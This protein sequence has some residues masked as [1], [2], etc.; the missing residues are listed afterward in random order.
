MSDLSSLEKFINSSKLSLTK[1]DLIVCDYLIKN[2]NDIP[3]MTLLELAS[4]T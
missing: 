4:E 2:L 3:N 1:T